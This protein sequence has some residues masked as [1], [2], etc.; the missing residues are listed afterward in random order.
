[1]ICRDAN[2][3]TMS[4]VVRYA[5]IR[6]LAQRPTLRVSPSRT[7]RA[8]SPGGRRKGATSAGPAAPLRGRPGQRIELKVA[9]LRD[10]RHLP[11][12]ALRAAWHDLSLRPRSAPESVAR[13][14]TSATGSWCR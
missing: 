4:C 10:R 13:L 14:D 7:T 2:P 12:V 11:L 9:Y 5:V 1:M 3:T 6:A 8:R